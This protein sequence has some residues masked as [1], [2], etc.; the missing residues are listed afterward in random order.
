MAEM[1]IDMIIML[2]NAEAEKRDATAIE[3][4]KKD[5][6]RCVSVIGEERAKEG[7]MA[8]DELLKKNEDLNDKVNALERN[9]SDI[10]N[11][12]DTSMFF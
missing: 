11:N 6:L 1:D 10:S 3:Q 8:I 5:L 4:A 7:V 2:N 12:V 9:L